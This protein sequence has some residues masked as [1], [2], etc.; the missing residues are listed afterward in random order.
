MKAAIRQHALEL[1]FDD[2][3]FTTAEPPESAARFLEWLEG[4]VLPG[5]AALEVKQ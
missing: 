1:G 2:C 5:V 4:K 3:R